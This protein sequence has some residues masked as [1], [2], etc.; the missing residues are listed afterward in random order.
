MRNHIRGRTSAAGTV[1]DQI[2]A[3]CTLSRS[4]V[5]VLSCVSALHAFAQTLGC[6][7]QWGVGM[8]Q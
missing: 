7:L 3:D 2:R 6:Q 1:F 8:E 4:A 5:A